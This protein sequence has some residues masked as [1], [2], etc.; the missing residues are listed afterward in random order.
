MMTEEKNGKTIKAKGKNPQG[1]GDG[2]GKSKDPKTCYNCRKTGHMA[3][4]CWNPK[5]FQQVEDASHNAHQHVAV[6]K[7]ALLR[8]CQAKRLMSEE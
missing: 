3:K 2:K 1:K 4:D 6:V 8:R 7:P 5:K